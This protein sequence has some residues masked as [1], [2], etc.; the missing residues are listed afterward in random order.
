MPKN[1]D[2][3]PYWKP[4]G[5]C[6]NGHSSFWKT[7]I[8]SPQWERWSKE[9]DSRFSK[10]A[11]KEKIIKNKPFFDVLECESCGIV[12]AKH[13]QEFMKFTTERGR[14]KE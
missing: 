5:G 10:F 6:P 14:R 4:C 12:S 9:N 8:E 13:F 11:R 3:V 2:A 7:V 1:S